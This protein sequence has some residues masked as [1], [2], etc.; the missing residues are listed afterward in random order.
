MTHTIK[1]EYGKVLHYESG[2]PIRHKDKTFQGEINTGY[3]D[4]SVSVFTGKG[5]ATKVF[6]THEL[7]KIQSSN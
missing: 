4:N 3:G 6:Y 7:I 5:T 2:V 1:N